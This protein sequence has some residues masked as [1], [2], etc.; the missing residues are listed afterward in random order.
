[1]AK[2]RRPSLRRRPTARPDHHSR[3]TNAPNGPPTRDRQDYALT[4]PPWRSAERAVAQPSLCSTSSRIPSRV[5]DR[6]GV[7]MRQWRPE[8]RIKPASPC[9]LCA[10]TGLPVRRPAAICQPNERRRTLAHASGST[11]LRHQTPYEPV[12]VA[13]AGRCRHCMLGGKRSARPSPSLVTGSSSISTE[14]SRVME[15]VS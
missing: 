7:G 2:S 14:S 11:I 9:R 10:A 1:M 15:G 5:D 3:V 8:F 12:A 4:R 13:H 6:L